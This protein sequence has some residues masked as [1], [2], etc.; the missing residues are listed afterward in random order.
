[1]QH[2]GELAK[3][4]L[5]WKSKRYY[6]FTVWVCSLRY[7]AC[8]VPYYTIL[9]SAVSLALP[10]FSIWSHKRNDFRKTLL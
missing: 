10:S 5:P 2:R 8:K 3:T 7:P 1:M 9:S 4:L 6:I